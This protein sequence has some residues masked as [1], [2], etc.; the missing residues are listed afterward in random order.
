M[1]LRLRNM[2]YGFTI[3]VD[4]DVEI[5]EI[6]AA[7]EKDE[8]SFTLSNILLGRFPIMLQ[9]ELC[10]LHGLTSQLRFNM[11][12]CMNDPGGY[13]IIDGKEKVIMSQEKFADNMLYVRDN[14]SDIYRYSAEIRSVSEDTSK[15]VRTA[16]VRMVSPT[17]TSSNGQIVVVIPNVRKPIPLFIAMRAL[18]LSSDKEIIEHCLL[19]MKKQA[20]LVELFTPS[21][22]DAGMIFTQQLALKYIS[23]FTKAK[24]IPAVLDILSNYF[25]P[26]VGELDF[27]CKAYFTGHMVFK[28]LNVATGIEQPTARDSFKYKRIDISGTLLRSLFKEYYTLQQKHLTQSIDKKYFYHI[29]TYQK[30]FTSL[31]TD[32]YVELF[33]ERIVEKGFRKAFKGSWGAEAHT[34]DIW[35]CSRFESTQL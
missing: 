23:T 9:S 35:G 17:P 5:V 21:I 2:T 13:F 20:S 18:G 6:N 3:H 12:E 29:G 11:G 26:H 16:A 27:I 31:F 32:N 34:Q 25:L 10:V 4:V 1:R 8:K 33:K 7:G 24:T 22:H 30:N 14:Y 28:M 15:H 19:N